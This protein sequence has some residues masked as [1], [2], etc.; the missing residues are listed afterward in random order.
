LKSWNNNRERYV[1]GSKFNE[2]IHLNR[3]NKSKLKLLQ[4]QEIAKCVWCSWYTVCTTLLVVTVYTLVADFFTERR[5]GT[6]PIGLP[7]SR[8]I[9]GLCGTTW[10]GLPRGDFYVNQSLYEHIRGIYYRIVY[11]DRYVISNHLILNI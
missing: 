10:H 9:S 5:T 4:F 3:D 8:L 7:Q 11:I 6:R 1:S 2:R